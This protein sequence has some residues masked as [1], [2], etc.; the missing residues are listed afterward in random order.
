MH[1]T[2]LSNFRLMGRT[3]VWKGRALLPGARGAGRGGTLAL[4]RRWAGG[5]QGG[6]GGGSSPAFQR[7]S[8]EPLSAILG[9]KTPLLWEQGRALIHLR[10]YGAEIIIFDHFRSIAGRQTHQKTTWQAIHRNK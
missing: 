8:R 3:F 1:H 10:V 5:A 9:V 4:E 6:G 7:L 2:Q